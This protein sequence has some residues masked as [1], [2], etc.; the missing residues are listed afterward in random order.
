MDWC[1]DF[2]HTK[3]NMTPI[4]P[5]EIYLLERYQSLEYF[6]EL[7]D[8]WGK[9]IAHLEAMVA[10]FIQNRPHS[11]RLQNFPDRPDITWGETVLPNFRRTFQDLCTGFIMVS[12]GDLEGLDYAGGPSN[13]FKG[14]M[15]FWT[16]W[17]DRDDEN[18][19]G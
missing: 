8:T 6:S 5:Q 2:T 12:R 14:H 1:G 3:T 10:T 19:Y 15:E 16:G 4:N 11:R 9:L 18:K 13:G 7:I 17:M